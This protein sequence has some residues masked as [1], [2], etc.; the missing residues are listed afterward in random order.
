MPNPIVW[1]FVVVTRPYEQIKIL[2]IR[3]GKRDNIHGTYPR[4]FTCH[5]MVG[6]RVL[7]KFP[8]K[9]WQK[10]FELIMRPERE[11]GS[12]YPCIKY[13]EKWGP[14]PGQWRALSRLSQAAFDNA[15]VD[16]AWK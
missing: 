14:I 7:V 2:R 11:D 3:N 15:G 1:K 6:D 8:G 16:P 13:G 12:S 5:L 10:K 4:G 9:S